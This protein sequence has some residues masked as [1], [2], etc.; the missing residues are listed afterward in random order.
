MTRTA[1]GT[2][3]SVDDA[4]AG[5]QNVTDLRGSNPRKELVREQL[6]DIAAQL[7]DSKGYAQTSINDIARAIGLGRSAVY[8]Y[9]RNK[10]EILAAL[11]EAEALTPSHQLK[12]LMTQSELTPGERLRRAVVDGIMRRLSSGSRFI[13]L[14]RLEAQIPEELGPLYNQGR[15]DIYDFYVRCISDG[16]ASGEFREV[17]PKVAAFAVI[18]MA[19]WTTR[20]Y[21]PSGPRSPAEIGEIIADMA[22]H[23]LTARDGVVARDAEVRDALKG[24]RDKVDLLERTL[25]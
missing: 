15:R 20:W 24:L 25:K 22:L 2:T 19:N 1:E 18:G 9:F 7:F 3:P 4:G 11:V 23:G 17:D 5:M 13:L 10:E 21:S 12:D 8:H 6:I 14:A 16:I